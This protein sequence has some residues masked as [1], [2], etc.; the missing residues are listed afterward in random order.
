[1]GKNIGQFSEVDTFGRIKLN[2]LWWL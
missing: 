1:L 2:L